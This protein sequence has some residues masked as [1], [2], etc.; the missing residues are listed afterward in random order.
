MERTPALKPLLLLDLDGV[1]RSFPPMSAELAAIA[2][3]PSLL[4]R[5]ITGEISDEQWREAVG[6]E[7]AAT[8]G[9]VIAE[10]L[11]L[12]R[13]ARRQCFV[14]LLSNATTRLEAD[15]ALLGLD[16]EVDAVFNSSRLG[17]AKPDPAIYRRVL[18]ELGYE[19]AVFCDDD[20]QNAAA[21]RAA[22]L[23]GVH[24]PDTAALRT[25]LAVR[26]L[27][28]PTVLLILP[29]RDEAEGLATELLESGWGPCAVHRDMLAGEDDAEDVDW[30]V[31]LTTAP[32]GLP[33]SAHRAA[34]DDLAEQHDGFTGEG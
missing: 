17:L 14:A 27:I 21:A 15:L 30:V 18:D 22:G 8:S 3:E 11:A 2:F 9:E 23:D 29:D 24:V 4:R 31:E 33:A 28:P 20:A 1:L 6:A 5:A 25:A 13:V 7:F 12:V 16:V 26:G 19:T 10:A 32:D 34:L